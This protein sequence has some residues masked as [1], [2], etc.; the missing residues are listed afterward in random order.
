MPTTRR[1]PGYASPLRRLC[2]VPANASA[3][4]GAAS[5]EASANDD[6]EKK[7]GVSVTSSWIDSSS[8]PA[9]SWAH[10]L[11]SSQYAKSSGTM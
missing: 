11:R 10:E 2:S 9:G 1:G 7:T 6:L 5:A 4:S 8:T 3:G